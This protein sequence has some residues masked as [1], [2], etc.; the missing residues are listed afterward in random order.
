LGV[1]LA[2][3]EGGKVKRYFATFATRQAMGQFIRMGVIG[4]FNTL[5]YFALFNLFRFAL[6][7]TTFWSVTAGFAIATGCSYVLNRRWTFRLGRS[8][9]SWGESGSFYVVN[10][11]SWA[12]TVAVVKGAEILWPGL[13][14]LGLNLANLV[15]T[16]VVLLP[17]FAAYRDLV[18]RRS[19]RDT[20]ETIVPGES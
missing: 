11:L 12:A 1:G 10:A 8:T 3:A 15:A 13:G 17:K 4:V 7:W 14:P 16:G 2:A 18:F 20:E 5:V 9:G 6:D 19:L